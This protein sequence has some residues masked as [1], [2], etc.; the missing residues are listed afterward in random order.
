MLFLPYYI[1]RSLSH[2]GNNTCKDKGQGLYAKSSLY[3]ALGFFQQ[4]FLLLDSSGPLT[5]RQ[6]VSCYKPY[7][8]TLQI[9]EGI[10]RQGCQHNYEYLRLSGSP[11]EEYGT[12]FRRESRLSG[13]YVLSFPIQ[14][15][16]LSY[17][18]KTTKGILVSVFSL[19]I[20]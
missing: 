6:N 16:F 11:I 18:L 12:D 1:I 7:T 3:L 17:I 10:C 8:L 19:S 4:S 13:H 15:P 9:G 14:E 2:K 5:C 20:I